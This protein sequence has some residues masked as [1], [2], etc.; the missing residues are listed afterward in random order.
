VTAL[1]EVHPD[2]AEL[3]RRFVDLSDQ[4]MVM[5]LASNTDESTNTAASKGAR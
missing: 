1:V 3:Q 2:P 4:A 5:M